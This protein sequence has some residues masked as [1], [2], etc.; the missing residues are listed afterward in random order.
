M[1]TFATYKSVRLNLKNS[2]LISCGVKQLLRKGSQQGGGGGRVA[3]SGELGLTINFIFASCDSR[4]CSS[5]IVLTQ[6]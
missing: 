4:H 6:D 1:R 3:K 2:I 5:E